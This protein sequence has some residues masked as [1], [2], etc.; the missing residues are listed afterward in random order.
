M[1]EEGA[2]L[3]QCCLCP[4]QGGALK[5][6]T[7]PPLWCHAT[8]MQWIPEVTVEDVARMEPVSHIENIQ[9]ER[10]ELT[11]CLCKYGPPSARG[12][13]P[14]A[15]VLGIMCCFCHAGVP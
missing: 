12:M 11:C 5:P 3:P 2:A 10:W 4:V 14:Y 9:K 8:C 7:L 13:L 1:Q 15:T 6:T